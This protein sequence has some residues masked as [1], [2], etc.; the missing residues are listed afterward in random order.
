MSLDGLTALVVDDAKTMRAVWRTL[1]APMGVSEV[2]EAPDAV[3]ALDLL[4]YETVD[5][6]IVDYQMPH[7]NGAEFVRLLRRSPD[8]PNQSIPIVMCTAHTSKAIIKELIDAG[9]DEVLGKPVSP[10]QAAKKCIAA[11]HQR[12]KLIREQGYAGPDRRRKESQVTRDRRS[13]AKSSQDSLDAHVRQVLLAVGG[14]K[15]AALA[16]LKKMHDERHGPDR[17]A[18]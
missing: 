3:E 13:G 2:L 9:A 15:K 11:I 5:F 8:S 10:G 4:G 17:K 7:L 1:L 12:R 18:S 16:M 14:D 6:L